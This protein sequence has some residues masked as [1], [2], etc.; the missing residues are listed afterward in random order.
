[1][2]CV[3]MTTLD[4]FFATKIKTNK[5]NCIEYFEELFAY[6]RAKPGREWRSL[7][8]VVIILDNHPVSFRFHTHP[9]V[10]PP[11]EAVHGLLERKKGAV[12][13]RSTLFQLS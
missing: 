3:E 9:D 11:F 8:R 13:I 10:E 4:T 12:R 1:M 5:E 7:S 2:G 6:L